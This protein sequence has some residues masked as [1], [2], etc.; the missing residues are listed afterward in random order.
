MNTRLRSLKLMTLVPMILWLDLA[1]TL[2]WKPAPQLN[3]ASGT[4]GEYTVGFVAPGMTDFASP[5][6]AAL[7]ASVL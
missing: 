5:V 1:E 2:P 4:L 7:L 3:R 6:S